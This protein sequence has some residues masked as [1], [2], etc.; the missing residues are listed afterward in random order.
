VFTLSPF[1]FTG[2]CLHHTASGASV[3]FIRFPQQS[4]FLLIYARRPLLPLVREFLRLVLSREG[5][6]VVAASPQGYLPLSA[7]EAAAERAKLE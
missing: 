3:C 6:E 4:R 2:D 1:S 7:A 5:Q